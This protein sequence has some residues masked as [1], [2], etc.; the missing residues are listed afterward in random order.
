[1]PDIGIVGITADAKYS[2]VKDEIPAQ[3]FLPRRQRDNPGILA[4][5]VR[6]F[7]NPEMCSWIAWSRCSP[8]LSLRSRRCW[9]PSACGATFVG[10]AAAALLF[11][12]TG[13]NPIVLATAA[14]VLACVI[15]AAGYLPARRAARVAPMEALRCE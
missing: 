7:G 12:L 14:I 15:A 11:G 1:M 9:R 4:F 10:R 3:Y 2:T 8:P 5:Y 13:D 6:G